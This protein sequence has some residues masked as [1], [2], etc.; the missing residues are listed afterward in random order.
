MDMKADPRREIKLNPEVPA[1]I[2]EIADRPWGA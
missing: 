2:F 1:E